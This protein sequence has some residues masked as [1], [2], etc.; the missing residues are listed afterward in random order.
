VTDTGDTA[1]MLD[2]AQRRW[3]DVHDRKA[4]LLRLAEAGRDAVAGELA[5]E[6]HGRRRARQQAALAR[7]SQL[8]DVDALLRDEAWR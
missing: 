1:A 7:G 3:P 5:S 6:E 4:L 2:F 8:V